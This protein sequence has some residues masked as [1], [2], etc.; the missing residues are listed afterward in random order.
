MNRKI[1]VA[2]IYNK[3]SKFLSG[4]H[5]DNTY[6]HFF[7]KALQRNEKII[8]SNFPTDDIFDAS[9]LKDKF[10]IILLWHNFEFEMPKK[11][12]GIQEL[13]IPVISK[14][15]DPKDVKKGLKKNKEW[16]IDYYFNIFPE[17]YFHELYPSNFKYKNVIM[18]LEPA[19]YQNVKPFGD[20]IKNKILNT[21]NVGNFRILSRI[22]DKIRN[23]KFTNLYGYYLRTISNQLP[24]V[25]Y[26]A[27]L[28]HEYVNDK[29]PLLLQKY[30]TSIAASSDAPTP[31]YWE[32]P[33]AGCLTFMEITNFNRGKEI[34]EFED[35]ES[36]IFINKNNYKEKFEEY[37]SD[38]D[39]KK[40][41]KIAKK[42]REY[43]LK[44]CNN[45]KGV[46]SLIEIM[47]ELT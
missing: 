15:N 8:V 19:L 23:P 13:D 27:T 46:E 9:I 14:S 28:Q 44:N 33:A 30:Q 45:D 36:A 25:D 7:M 6:Y 39:N 18:G 34:L 20:R 40:W 3:S 11:I 21:G 47:E 12:L 37:L 10:D 5:Y 35:G 31:K 17:S 16:K 29:Y 2:F 26:T 41:E 4:N 1:K 24:Y 32:I 42:G 38:P 22:R 43:V